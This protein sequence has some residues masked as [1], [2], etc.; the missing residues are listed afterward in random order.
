[1]LSD[2]WLRVKRILAVR[3]DNIGDIVLLSPALRIL[4]EQLPDA[5]ITLL[6]SPAGSQV[7]PLLPW[8][9]DVITWRAVWQDISGEMGGNP[10]REY[11]LVNTLREGGFDAAVIFTSFS[12]SPYPPAYACYLAGIPI[13]L[14]HSREFGGGVLSEW[15]QPPADESHQ[16]ERNLSLLASAGF[17]INNRALELHIPEDVQANA[18]H[19]LDSL[20]L[21]PFKPFILVAPGASAN[22]R[23]YPPERFADVIQRIPEKTGLPVVVVGSERETEKIAPVLQTTTRQD[24]YSL[25]GV[26]SVAELAALIRRANLVVANNSASLHIADAFL[27]PVVVL[28]SGTELESQWNPR[29]SLAKL[30]RR[31]TWCSP[32]YRFDCPYHLECLDISPGA[33]I[34]SIV[35]VLEEAGSKET[36]DARTPA[37]LEHQTIG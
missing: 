28:Y 18:D 9:K 3:L 25:V 12:Q 23:R 8:V 26:T 15:Y 21:N 10:E 32:C 13:R 14:G 16:A 7:V 17:E 33:I 6:A 34:R 5:Q 31:P 4:Q 27:T 37:L 30:L 11:T 35:D 24:I 29:R 36:R 19:L 20:G 2:A 1:M 22:A